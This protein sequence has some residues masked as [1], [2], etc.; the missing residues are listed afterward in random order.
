MFAGAEHVRRHADGGAAGLQR[1][2]RRT[3]GDAAHHRYGD[4]TVAV[5]FG[6]RAADL[7]ERAF[8]DA[9]RKTAAAIA[10]AAAGKLRQLDDLDGAGAIGQ[11]A[12]E[13]AL[14]EGCDEAM[15]A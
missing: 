12:N 4:R 9:G 6:A 3:G 7:A 1:L 11:A 5:I 13:A 2:D 10:V 8:D 15:D 14:F